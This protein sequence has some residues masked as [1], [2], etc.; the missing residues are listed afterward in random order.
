MDTR[1]NYQ[2]LNTAREVA[3]KT[4]SG[5]SGPSVED[6]LDQVGLGLSNLE[7]ALREVMGH[8]GLI[9]PELQPATPVPL[10]SVLPDRRIAVLE[11]MRNRLQELIALVHAI[12]REVARL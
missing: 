5:L 4:Q 7:A 9:D 10:P 11:M 6:F 12:D 8:L 2:G 1:P 3:L